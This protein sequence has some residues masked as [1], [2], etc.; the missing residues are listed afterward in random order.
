MYSVQEIKERL[1][2]FFESKPINKAWIF[3]SYARGEQT[4]QSDIDILVDFN[5]D[6]YPSLLKHAGF[7]LELEEMLDSKI[8]L[9]PLDCLY[10]YVKNTI[11]KDK[12]LIYERS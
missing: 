10:D 9:I 1:Q 12:I 4:K 11:E 8:D 2:D 6:N 7:I 5:R 3:G